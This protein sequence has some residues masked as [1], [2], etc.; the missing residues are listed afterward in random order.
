VK[1]TRRGPDP[2][3]EEIPECKR[4][5]SSSGKGPFAQRTNNMKGVRL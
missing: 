4:A 5:L 3:R 2:Q 1:I